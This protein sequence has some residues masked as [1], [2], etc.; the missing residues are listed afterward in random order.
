MKTVYLECC[1]AF[2]YRRQRKM[3]EELESKKLF[4]TRKQTE[5]TLYNSFLLLQILHN[6]T[7]TRFYTSLHINN[8]FSSNIFSG[9]SSTNIMNSPL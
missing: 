5:T 3:R 4:C 8:C 2:L 9:L 6:T 1:H 7:A